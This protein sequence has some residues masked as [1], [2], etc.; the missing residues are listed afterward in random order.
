MEKRKKMGSPV[1][2]SFDKNMLYSSSK[3]NKAKNGPPLANKVRDNQQ[4][5]A[6]ALKQSLPQI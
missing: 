3:T 1:S 2:N 6:A 5:Q 4:K